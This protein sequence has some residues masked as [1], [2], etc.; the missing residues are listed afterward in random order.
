MNK[1]FLQFGGINK[2]VSSNYTRNNY[3]NSDNLTVPNILGNSRSKIITASNLDI[4]NNS[5]V[6]VD[7]IYFY[8]GAYITSKI[9][10]FDNLTVTG[11][12]TVGNIANLNNVITENAE[13]NKLRVDSLTFN[14][15]PYKQT[16]PFYSLHITDT[17]IDE[18]SIYILNQYGQIVDMFNGGVPG[19]TGPTGPTGD[20]GSTGPDGPLGNTGA[21]GY[22]GSLGYTGTIGPGGYTG[23][24]GPT[25]PTGSTGSTGSTGPT[26]PTGPTGYTGTIGDTGPTG[27]TGPG[28]STGA[29][30][31]KGST[32]VTGPIGPTGSNGTI[33]WN[34]SGST[35][36]FYNGNVGILNTTPQYSLDISGNV[37][38]N[39]AQTTVLSLTANE[40]I[41]AQGF[42]ATS[43]YRIKENIIPLD[44]CENSNYCTIDNLQPLI[45]KNKISNQLNMG[46]IAHEVHE[47]FPFLVLGNKDDPSSYQS[48]NYIGLIPLLIHEIKKLKEE[49]S[50]QQKELEYLS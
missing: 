20:K 44:Q 15:S 39:S 48:I 30:G 24:I 38:I 13:I 5:I 32:G 10:A 2:S 21:Q 31:L 42:Y 37:N 19:P 27:V 45:Y 16:T 14:N 18:P 49:C 4:S 34:I 23:P 46:L 43:D 36:I 11:N 29:T 25:G 1:R 33:L 35:G 22:T 26:G 12:L 47:I 17:T 8:N 41:Q 9:Y 7:G 40:T 3:C 50:Q 6:N 28:G